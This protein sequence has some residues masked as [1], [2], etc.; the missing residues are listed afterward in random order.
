LDVEDG[1]EG[2]RVDLQL[3]WHIL[4]PGAVAKSPF[5]QLAAAQPSVVPGARNE[6]EK[7][8]KNERRRKCE[9]EWWRGRAET[10]KG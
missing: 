10:D 1:M 5:T 8:K 2:G 4:I 7:K 3:G 6:Q 9:R